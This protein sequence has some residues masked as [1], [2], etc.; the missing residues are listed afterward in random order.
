LSFLRTSYPFLESLKSLLLLLI[1][2]EILLIEERVRIRLFISH[3][4]AFFS[5]ETFMFGFLTNRTYNLN[6][7][8][9]VFQLDTIYG[10]GDLRYSSR[11]RAIFAVLML[12]GE[13]K[14]IGFFV[15][16]MQKDYG[17]SRRI[18]DFQFFGGLNL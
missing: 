10:Y 2:L 17:F 1:I 3:S 13:I 12:R 4:K 11:H 7:K 6:W 8:S 16:S 18:I 5:I 15:F 14:L 9:L